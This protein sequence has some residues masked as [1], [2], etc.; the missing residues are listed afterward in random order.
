MLAVE[1]FLNFL[2]AKYEMESYY[3]SARE[4][5]FSTKENLEKTLINEFEELAPP[6]NYDQILFDS[7]H[8]EKC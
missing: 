2:I 4:T 6:S 5:F 7:R 1:I 8:D 3:S